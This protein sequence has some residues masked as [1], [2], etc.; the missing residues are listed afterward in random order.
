MRQ[1]IERFRFSLDKSSKKFRC[2]KCSKKRFVKYVDYKTGEY[3]PNGYGRCDRES[4]CG[5]FKDPY[6]EG[7]VDGSSSFRQ[8]KV[9]QK[10]KT[11]DLIPKNVYQD[12]LRGYRKNRFVEYL[13][14]LFDHRT[15]QGLIQNYNI[16][17]SKYWK[18]ATVFWQIDSNNNIRTGKVMLYSLDGHRVKKPF[19]HINWVHSI[20]YNRYNL[21][22]CLFGEHLLTCDKTIPV[23]I[24]ESEKTAI[25]SSVYFPEFIWLAVGAKSNLKP[26]RCN[27]LV[28][29]R[30]I[31]FPDLGAYE[32]WKKRAKSLSYFCEV[33]VSDLLEENSVDISQ[34][35]GYD[36][37]DYLIQ[38]TI[39]EFMSV[40]ND[41]NFTY[42]GKL[43]EN[44][45]PATWDDISVKGPYST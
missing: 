11:I 39:E 3:L 14:S 17:T 10:S 27:S 8:K 6:R 36:L 33:Q 19:S 13:E 32:D 42:D 38:Y 21:E 2:P 16:G 40:N 7:Y 34:T 41:N 31:L 28:G 18:G 24:V 25:I 15:V 26:E 12:S 43:T 35:E 45:Y 4:S 37:A 1:K 22:Q 23:A 20:L 9:S 29:R 30:V 44:G 5:F